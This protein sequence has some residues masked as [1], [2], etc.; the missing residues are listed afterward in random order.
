[1]KYSVHLGTIFYCS[2]I[3]AMLLSALIIWVAQRIWSSDP[4][5]EKEAL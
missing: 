5:I 3:G 4:S 2:N 1:M